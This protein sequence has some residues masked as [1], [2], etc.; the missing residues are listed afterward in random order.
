MRN[1]VLNYLN[2]LERKNS[3]VVIVVS[4]SFYSNENIAFGSLPLVAINFILTNTLFSKFQ[5][6]S[7]DIACPLHS[8]NIALLPKGE[9]DSTHFSSGA[10]LRIVKESHKNRSVPGIQIRP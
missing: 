5:L 3:F 9:H 4:S 7:V 1:I 10:R 8:S 6:I 2:G